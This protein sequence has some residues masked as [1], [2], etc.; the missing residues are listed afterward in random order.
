MGEE[1][2]IQYFTRK[3]S[4]M[5]WIVG[6]IGL[7]M[8]YIGF[9]RE[10]RSLLFAAVGF[11][12]IGLCLYEVISQKLHK[13][14]GRDLDAIVEELQSRQNVWGDAMRELCLDPADVSDYEPF[15]LEGYSAAPI[16]T[17]PYCRRD[18]EDGLLR[19][20][21]YQDS[22]FLLGKDRFYVYSSVRS[23]VDRE[24]ARTGRM[25]HYG[26]VGEARIVQ[27][28]LTYAVGGSSEKRETSEIRYLLLKDRNGQSYSFAF[29]RSDDPQAGV[30]ALLA[31]LKRNAAARAEG[32]AAKEEEADRQV[33][34]VH[35]GGRITEKEYD[36]GVIGSGLKE[37]VP[38][39]GAVKKKKK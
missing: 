2:A 21:N 31:A 13:R 16:H 27:E 12:M 39:G 30:E 17:R 7:A 24:R 15:Y 14:S 36:I 28:E 6:I 19:T 1:Q 4:I 20:S 3:S 32:P 26:R 23:L 8:V 38:P 25:W 9:F 5:V 18:D 11:V 37:A 22:L 10:R 33:A 29:D 35:T 34:L